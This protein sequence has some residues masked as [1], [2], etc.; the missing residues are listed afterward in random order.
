MYN[1]YNSLSNIGQIAI[2]AILIALL[3][4][5]V[6]DYRIGWQIA[7]IFLFLALIPAYFLIWRRK[8]LDN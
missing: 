6:G 2:G 8:S 1:L 4:V 5:F 7:C 3:V